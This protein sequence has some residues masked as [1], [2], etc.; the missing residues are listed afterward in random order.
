MSI[1]ITSENSTEIHVKFDYLPER[2]S[3]IK[4]VPSHRWDSVRKMWILK[5]NEDILNK[6]KDIFS[7]EEIIINNTVIKSDNN[8]PKYELKTTAG[9]SFEDLKCSNLLADLLKLKGYSFKTR[10]SYVAHIRRLSEYY[11]K[12]PENITIDEIKSYLIYLLETKNSSHSYI[13]QTISAVKMLYNEILKAP[14][15]Y[16]EIPRP[17]KQRRLPTILSEEEVYKILENTK[18]L[19]HKTLLYLLYSG[20]FR[21]GEVVRLRKE[22]IDPQR[23]LIHIIQGKGAKDRYTVLS[24]V[25]Y[26]MLKLYIQIYKPE[27]WLFPGGNGKGHITERTVEK[28]CEK[29]SFEAHITKNVTPHTLRHCFATHSLENGIDIRFI[30]EMLGHNDPK[31]TQIYTHVTEKSLQKIQSPLDRMMGR[32]KKD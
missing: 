28:I 5:N 6:I 32:L 16:L 9:S 21:V 31:T 17:K 2:V 13:N 14:L 29:V 18:N 25:A 10:K 22:D 20:G 1:Y 26:E 11:K 27:T 19:K 30:Q 7:N 8:N 3:K 15:D 23:M 12:Q 24:P 4:S